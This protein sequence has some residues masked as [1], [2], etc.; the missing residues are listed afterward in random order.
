MY[1]TTIIRLPYKQI[2]CIMFVSG[3][4]LGSI[5]GLAFAL[6]SPASTGISGGTFIA[7][8]TGLSSGF[9]GLIYTAVFNTLA[10]TLGGIT[11]DI[12]ELPAPSTE[13]VPIQQPPEIPWH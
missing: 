9:L 3:I 6:I 4:C 10:P 13:I 5:M 2:F 11:L 8:L 7:L 12:K 1:H